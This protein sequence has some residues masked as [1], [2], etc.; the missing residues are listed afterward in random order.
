MNPG[1]DR[2]T[3][4]EGAKG[5]IQWKGTNVCMDVYCSCGTHS[6]IDDEF[7]YYLRCPACGKTFMVNGHVE[8]VE[9]TEAETKQVER[10]SSVTLK[11]PGVSDSGKP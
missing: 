3:I 11:H 10:E 5:W 9:L 2:Q 8:L 6:H 7:T 4:P 1:W